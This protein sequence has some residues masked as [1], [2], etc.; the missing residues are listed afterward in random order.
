MKVYV[1]I[2][3]YNEESMISEVIHR[4]KKFTKNIIVVDDGSKDK[5]SKVDKKAGAFVLRHKINL[6]QGAARMTGCEAAWRM[7]AEVVVTLDADGQHN[8]IHISKF[9]KKIAEGY[10]IVFGQ[11]NLKSGIPL[12]R[13]LGLKLGSMIIRIFFGINIKDLGC[14]FRAFTKKAYSKIKWNPLIRYGSETEMVARTGKNKLKYATV[15]IETIYIDKYKG[16]TIIDAL[17]I[18]FSIPSWLFS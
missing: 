13:R 16:M 2:P 18:I 12:D 4:V 5:T 17:V 1:V 7:G 14:V 11:R 3:A 15:P 6:G 8:P 10:D 9:V